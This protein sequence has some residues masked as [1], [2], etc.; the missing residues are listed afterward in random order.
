MAGGS[1]CNGRCRSFSST[2]KR[3]GTATSGDATCEVRTT[4]LEVESRS[5]GL[6][7][8]SESHEVGASICERSKGPGATSRRRTA[9]GGL[10]SHD[11]VSTDRT[12]ES[13][14]GMGGEGGGSGGLREQEGGGGGGERER[15]GGGEGGGG[16]QR[17]GG[18]QG[19]THDHS[20]TEEM[21][22]DALGEV[23]ENTHTAS[24]FS[25][26]DGNLSAIVRSSLDLI[27]PPPEGAM[28]ISSEENRS[29]R[30]TT[31]SQ[32][33][34]TPNESRHLFVDREIAM[35]GGDEEGGFEAR[36]CGG[37]GR[38]LRSRTASQSSEVAEGEKGS[39][40]QQKR[41]HKVVILDVSQP[42]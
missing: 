3:V 33:C 17:E 8:I 15:G 41:G 35:E 4:E 7:L 32:Q 12:T 2:E 1:H 23:L 36:V 39:A 20:M 30:I 18:G 5:T 26:G 16:D 28:V 40:R 25:P 13:R 42:Q 22:S 37:T 21:I 27:C 29:D 10:D 38:G 31:A 14:R 9:S 24:S 19:R 6:P 34:R 11:G